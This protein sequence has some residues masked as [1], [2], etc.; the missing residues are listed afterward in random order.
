MEWCFKAIVIK[1]VS[2]V[3]WKL[4]S[5]VMMTNKVH[6][7][8]LSYKERQLLSPAP[9]NY[10]DHGFWISHTHIHTHTHAHQHPIVGSKIFLPG[11][12]QKKSRDQQIWKDCGSKVKSWSVSKNCSSLFMS[13]SITHFCMP[14]AVSP[15]QPFQSHPLVLTQ[16]SQTVSWVFSLFPYPHAHT[17]AI[18]FSVGNTSVSPSTYSFPLASTYPNL[19]MLSS[20]NL[21]ASSSMK[22]SMILKH[23]YPIRNW[24]L[25]PRNFLFLCTW[26]RQCDS[27]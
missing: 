17:Y 26:L 6:S 7:R 14:S 19:L 20:P 21:N 8:G 18:F 22:S 16:S 15:T 27:R 2:L 13:S 5:I 12:R 3:Q 23:S 4:P 9:R 10:W 1:I 25:P 11:W 24:S